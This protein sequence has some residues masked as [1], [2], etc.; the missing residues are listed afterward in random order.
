MVNSKQTLWHVPSEGIKNFMVSNDRQFFL[1]VWCWWATWS[2]Y[3]L[4]LLDLLMVCLV[5][6]CKHRRTIVFSRNHLGGLINLSVFLV[7]QVQNNKPNRFACF[8]GWSSLEQQSLVDLCVFLVGQAHNNKAWAV[9][10]F[11]FLLIRFKTTKPIQ[12]LC[13]LLVDFGRVSFSRPF[14][15]LS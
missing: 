13:V 11:V 6:V 3:L 4:L 15:D 5:C 10:L 8:L 9:G 14:S 1:C 12:Y 7:N 2:I